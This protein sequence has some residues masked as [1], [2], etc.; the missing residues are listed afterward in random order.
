MRTGSRIYPLCTAREHIP[1]SGARQQPPRRRTMDTAPMLKMQ[2]QTPAA[3]PN[4]RRQRRR[5]R[6]PA[7]WA[8]LQPE[9]PIPL[10]GTIHEHIL[11]HGAHWP[12]PPRHRTSKGQRDLCRGTAVGMVRREFDLSGTLRKV[13]ATV[14]VGGGGGVGVAHAVAVTVGAGTAGLT[15]LGAGS[16]RASTYIHPRMAM[17]ATKAIIGQPGAFTHRAYQPY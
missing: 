8:P 3:P 9:T 16:S 7:R 15:G 1:G 5:H 10:S 12:P 13:G 6:H 17:A 14:A 4:L 2:A 11:E